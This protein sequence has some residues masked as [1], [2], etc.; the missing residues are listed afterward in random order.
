MWNAFKIHMFSVGRC[1]YVSFGT[2]KGIIFLRLVI[3]IVFH[4]NYQ[5]KYII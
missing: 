5:V 3:N 1:I 4:L 2:I